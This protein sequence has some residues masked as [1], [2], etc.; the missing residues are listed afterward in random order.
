MFWIPL[1]IQITDASARHR[2][3]RKTNR[4]LGCANMQ[5]S[6]PSHTAKAGPFSGNPSA[7]ATGLGRELS[8]RRIRCRRRIMRWFKFHAD[9][10]SDPTLQRRPNLDPRPV[11]SPPDSFRQKKRRVQSTCQY[12]C[13]PKTRPLTFNLDRHAAPLTEPKFWGSLPFF[14]AG[15]SP[16]VSLQDHTVT[17]KLCRPSDRL[18][19]ITAGCMIHLGKISGFGG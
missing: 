6:Q 4:L 11:R 1:G 3:P 12:E 15:V 17:R 18:T 16:D 19:R 13:Q 7:C 14:R 9:L 5:Y 8:N 2:W 10:I